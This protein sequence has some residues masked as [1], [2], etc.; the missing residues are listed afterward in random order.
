LRKLEWGTKHGINIDGQRLTHLWFADDV[1]LTSSSAKDLE[2]ILRD[3]V[4]VNRE[5]GL[6]M[7]AS[8]TKIM[9]NPNIIPIH[10]R[11]EQIEYVTDYIYLGQTHPHERRT[12]RVRDGLH[13]PRSAPVLSKLTRKRNEKTYCRN[14][15][16]I[17]EPETHLNGQT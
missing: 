14:L 9:T 15:E 11:G 12:D 10:M 7:N 13:L 2:T 1:I 4:T 17:L 3:L 6:T 5:I 8:K 16:E